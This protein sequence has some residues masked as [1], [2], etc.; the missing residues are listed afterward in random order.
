MK[1]L[2][3][4]IGVLLLVAGCGGAKAPAAEVSLPAVTL[5]AFDATS[6][7]ARLSDLRG[8]LVINLWAQWCGPCRRDLPLYEQ[9]HVAHPEVPVLGVNWRESDHAKAVRLLADKGVTYPSVIDADGSVLRARVGLPNV[10]LIDAKG[11]IAYQG[12]LEITS[13]AQLEKLVRAHL[14]LSL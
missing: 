12:A 9:F 14:G 1:R 6:E 13:L 8:P 7:P 2:A 4:V 10:L 5:P 3:A 11:R